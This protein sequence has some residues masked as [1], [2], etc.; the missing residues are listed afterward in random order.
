[1]NAEPHESLT[2][3][4]FPAWEQRRDTK[5]EFVNGHVYRVA[6]G[7]FAHA[8]LAAKLLASLRSRL[9]TGRVLG[10]NILIEM[11]TSS[12]YADVV[13]T[14]DERDFDP[15]GMVIRFPKL[16]VEVLSEETATID[17]CTKMREYQAIPTLEEYVIMTHECAGHKDSTVTKDGN[18]ICLSLQVNSNFARWASRSSWMSCIAAPA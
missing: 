7:T 13:V 9:S 6:N 3:A 4:E 18:C 2:Q 16:I 8:D 12:R 10:S 15:D 17:L 11:A 5:H 1:M 14:H